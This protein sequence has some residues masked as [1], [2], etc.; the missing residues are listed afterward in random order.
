MI[1]SFTAI[2]LAYCS[3][4]LAELSQC[5]HLSVFSRFRFS[6]AATTCNLN[7]KSN[8]KLDRLI[9]K[10]CIDSYGKF[11]CWYGSLLLQIKVM[12]I[13]CPDPV[14]LLSALG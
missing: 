11:Y 6:N 5:M 3:T 2:N 1:E 12:Q 8:S 4:D 14:A 13:A 10:A 9:Q 7:C